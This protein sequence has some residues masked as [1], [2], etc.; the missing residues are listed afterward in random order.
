M[1]KAK[2]KIGGVMADKE[3]QQAV[4]SA[5][6]IRKLLNKKKPKDFQ[7]GK[8]QL[9]CV[10]EGFYCGELKK[11]LP[12][13]IFIHCEELSVKKARKLA[14]WLLSAADYLEAKAYNNT[15]E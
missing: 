13:A 6:I 1:A 7:H 9:A 3:F 14:K 15:G 10:A 8:H 5:K 12:D 11:H 4:R 2:S